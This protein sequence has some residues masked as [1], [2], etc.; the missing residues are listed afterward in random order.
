MF[1]KQDALN[2]YRDSVQNG[3]LYEAETRIGARSFPVVGGLWPALK[4]LGSALFRPLKVAGA[5]TLGYGESSSPP[6]MPELPKEF[7]GTD[8]EKSFKDSWKLNQEVV[9]ARV[10]AFAQLLDLDIGGYWKK[11]SVA[12]HADAKDSTVLF[13][14]ECGMDPA[15]SN[16]HFVEMVARGVGNGIGRGQ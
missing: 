3:M 2:A 7:T 6:A 10:E 15:Q 16:G 9:N 4:L 5:L 13:P 14:E 12:S 11:S 8:L 1:S